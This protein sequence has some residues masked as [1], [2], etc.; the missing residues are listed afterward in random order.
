[1]LDKDFNA[2]HDP[3]SGHRKQC[4]WGTVPNILRKS[5]NSFFPPPLSKRIKDRYKYQALHAPANIQHSVQ[6][7]EV[8]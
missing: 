5:W 3:K 1:M 4:G 7:I 8:H 2:K 6:L